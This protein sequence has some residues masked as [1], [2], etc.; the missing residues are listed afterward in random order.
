VNLDQ[1][2]SVEQAIDKLTTQIAK[3]AVDPPDVKL[4]MGFTGIDY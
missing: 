3:E 2:Q 1:L 4:L